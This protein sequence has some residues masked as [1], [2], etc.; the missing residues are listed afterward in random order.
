M[1]RLTCASQP[2]A[3]ALNTNCNDIHASVPPVMLQ[4]TTRQED[5]HGAASWRGM[6]V[7][8][9]VQCVASD[10]FIVQLFVAPASS[11][12]DPSAR[13]MGR[14]TAMGSY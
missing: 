12:R 10:L 7:V 14:Q 1:P 9:V 2:R 6:Q 5:I 13:W 11:R 3:V 4:Q 8:A